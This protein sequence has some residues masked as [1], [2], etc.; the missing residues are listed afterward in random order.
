MGFSNCLRSKPPIVPLSETLY[1]GGCFTRQDMH[2]FSIYNTS[3]R[4]GKDSITAILDK[5]NT[6]KSRVK[7]ARLAKERM[8]RRKERL[9]KMKPARPAIRVVKR[10]PGSECD[11]FGTY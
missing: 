1:M 6:K 3:I 8:K 10:M 4:E 7:R 11:L 5:I 9:S 2:T